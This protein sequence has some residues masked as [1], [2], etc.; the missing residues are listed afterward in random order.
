MIDKVD[1]EWFITLVVMIWL[2]FRKKEKPS[3][4]KR[5]RKQKR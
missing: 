4:R 5:R 1:V 3:N 2:E